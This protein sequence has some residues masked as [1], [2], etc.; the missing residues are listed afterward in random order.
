MSGHE[1]AWAP[2]M[3]SIKEGDEGQEHEG[4]TL[5]EMSALSFRP[6]LASGTRAT[7]TQ[8]AYLNALINALINA[9]VKSYTALLL[10][11]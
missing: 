5:A 8:V 6:C 7:L 9:L 3:E 1:D 11:N 4:K 2:D 10:C